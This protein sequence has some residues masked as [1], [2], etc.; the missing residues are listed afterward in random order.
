VYSDGIRRSVDLNM[1][2]SKIVIFVLAALI[3]VASY[4]LYKT[5]QRLKEID[6]F[7]SIQEPGEEDDGVIGSFGDK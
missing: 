6:G 4:I 3:I 7:K 5:R 2:M 1:S